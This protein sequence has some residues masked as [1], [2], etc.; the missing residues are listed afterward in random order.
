MTGV[1][2]AARVVAGQVVGPSDQLFQ[3]IDPA[4]LMVEA[5]VFDQIDPDAVHEATA[6]VV[7]AMRPSS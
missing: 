4:S 3:I 2:A 5:L 6:S 1:I 7:G